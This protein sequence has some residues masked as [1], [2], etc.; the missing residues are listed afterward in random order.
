[1]STETSEKRVHTR[2]QFFLV[3]TGGELV[4]FFSFRPEHAPQ[5]IPALVV[6]LSDG[7]VQILSANSTH[8]S[9]SRYLLEL[10]TGDAPQERKQYPVHKVWARPD[11]INIKTGF[12]FAGNPEV[13]LGL[14]NLLYESEHHI[15]RC[16]L[17]PQSS[18]S[19]N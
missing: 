17:Y 11:G 13:T 7:G 14:Q 12:A 10:V 9:E 6:D 16:V 18:Q 4:S 19:G 15:L 3:Q 2:S 8:L 5:A 1:M